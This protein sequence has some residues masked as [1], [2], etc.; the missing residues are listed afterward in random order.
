MGNLQIVS[1]EAAATKAHSAS[2]IA[3]HDDFL[4]REDQQAIL[5]FLRGPGWGYGGGYGPGY[6]GGG[7]IP[8]CDGDWFWA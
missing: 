8:C 1:S 4:G 3:I 5:G 2:D 6:Y 7:G